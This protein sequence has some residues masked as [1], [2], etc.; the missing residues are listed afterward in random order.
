MAHT[1]GKA[2][3]FFLLLYSSDSAYVPENVGFV[4]HTTPRGQIFL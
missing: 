1:S 2:K 3:L 4:V